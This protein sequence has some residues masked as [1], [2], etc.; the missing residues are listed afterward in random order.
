MR[1]EKRKRAWNTLIPRSSS[2]MD[3]ERGYRRR[4]RIK[5]HKL[6]WIKSTDSSSLTAA[7]SHVKYFCMSHF[8]TPRISTTW[9]IFTIIFTSC[10]YIESLYIYQQIDLCTLDTRGIL[11][12]SY[13][14]RYLFTY[15]SDN[16]GQYRCT[17]TLYIFNMFATY[18][19]NYY[20]HVNMRCIQQVSMVTCMHKNKHTSYTCRG[21][22]SSSEGGNIKQSVSEG[23]GQQAVGST[24]V[25]MG[26]HSWRL[27]VGPVQ[28]PECSITMSGSV[29]SLAWGYH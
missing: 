16:N 1:L 8:L 22:W 28:P 7:I 14:I 19:Y 5:E 6:D 18:M 24:C 9:S 3:W 12:W 29:F 26:M 27:L 2:H 11:V 21:Y 13:H 23:H 25:P 15:N 17:H 10:W 4:Q 20:A